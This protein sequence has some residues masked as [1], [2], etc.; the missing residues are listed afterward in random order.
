MNYGTT[1]SI[2]K[3][4]SEVLLPDP[5][6][7]GLVFESNSRPFELADMHQRLSEITLNPTLPADVRL[8]FETSRNLMLYAWFVFEFQTIAELQ[9]YA[10]L[11]L[12]LRLRFPEAKREVRRKGSVHVVPFGL[13]PLL[14]MVVK[15]GLI[16]PS[17]LPAWERVQARR[18]WHEERSGISLGRPLSV[19]EWQ[20]ALLDAI[21][22]LRNNLAHGNPSLSLF[23]SLHALEL[24]ADLI[25]AL[26]ASPTSSPASDR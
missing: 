15:E 14:K 8:Q 3:P 12:A 2:L 18:K 23:D 13:S 19:S 20:D 16:V 6:F 10:A 9:A 5:R 24:C 22:N 21:P 26:F 7:Q 11:E 25:N 4:L 1:D 17:K